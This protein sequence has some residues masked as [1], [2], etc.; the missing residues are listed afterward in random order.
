MGEEVVFVAEASLAWRGDFKFNA[1]VGD[2]PE[3]P[4]DEPPEIGG[5]ASGFSPLDLLAA[6]IG[7]CLSAALIFCLK[8]ARV[9]PVEVSVKSKVTVVR[10]DGYLRVKR[11]D[12]DLTPVFSGEAMKKAERCLEI[13]RNYCIVTESVAR[14]IPVTVNLNAKKS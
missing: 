6:S 9:E 7:G 8:K 13:F 14:G 2:L 11:V 5:E 4:M 3:L 1:K 12:V 10:E